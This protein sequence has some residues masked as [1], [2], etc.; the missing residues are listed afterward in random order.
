[1]NGSIYQQISDNIRDGKLAADFL[2]EEDSPSESG[3]RFAPGAR[4]GIARYHM[5]REQLSAGASKEMVKA[6]KC[7]ARGEGTA[8]DGMFAE[9]CREHRVI[10]VIDDLQNYIFTHKNRLDPDGLYRTAIY[11][12]LYSRHIECVKVG[13]VIL[14]LM[15]EPGHDVK[16]II[17]RL[18]LSDEFTIFA[19][20]NMNTWTDGNKEIFRL[21]KLT[22]G[23]GRIH[24]VEELEPKTEEIR[25]WILK[26]GTKNNIAASYSA[27]TAWHKSGAAG[28]LDKD[29]LTPAEYRGLASIMEGLLD[30]GPMP[31]ISKVE[32]RE[33]VLKK[34]NA[35][36][37]LYAKTDE[38]GKHYAQ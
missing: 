35:L 23:W 8:A 33:E 24:A 22:E 28:L 2:I 18:G 26:E 31:G 21:A 12:I 15:G 10:Q 1:M 17:R 16:E 9:W 29:S 7:A 14:E 4:D 6:I 38:E 25:N 27:L 34:F 3:V 19:L 37:Q 32:N 30:E 5:G 11:L 20:W 36:S 13:L